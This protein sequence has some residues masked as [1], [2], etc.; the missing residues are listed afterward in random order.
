MK[1]LIVLVLGLVFCGSPLW[2]KPDGTYQI[3]VTGTNQLDFGPSREEAQRSLQVIHF[4]G[5]F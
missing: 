3:T 4:Y 2:A 5:F 1:K